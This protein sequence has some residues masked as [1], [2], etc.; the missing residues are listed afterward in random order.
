MKHINKENKMNDKE[1]RIIEEL[2][3]RFDELESW[4]REIAYDNLYALEQL[5][6]HI[7]SEYISHG[8]FGNVGVQHTIDS[9]DLNP[10]LK[11]FLKNTVFMEKYAFV[12]QFRYS[13]WTPPTNQE[14]RPEDIYIAFGYDKKKK[15]MVSI[16]VYRMFARKGARIRN[17]G[18]RSFFMPFTT[19]Y[20]KTY[21][22]LDSGF[23][24]FLKNTLYADS[25]KKALE[26]KKKGLA[27]YPHVRSDKSVQIQNE[28][29]L[30]PY[31]KK[32]FIDWKEAKK[33]TD[34]PDLIEEVFLIRH[35]VKEDNRIK[36]M[37]YSV[38]SSYQGGSFERTDFHA[39]D[40]DKAVAEVY[41][42]LNR[43]YRREKK[44]NKKGKK[45]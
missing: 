35:L 29:F 28:G 2:P 41:R 12:M 25:I 7:G 10:N 42:Q 38:E 1:I 34:R 31:Y 11:N 26:K 17:I 45:K 32:Y 16:L 23:S 3:K 27:V 44:K 19:D 33:F 18:G 4:N 22:E 36:T 5:I 6:D 15:H 43:I 9:S 37:H 30:A 40:K 24:V 13:E 39:N 21:G 8:S 14:L 20:S